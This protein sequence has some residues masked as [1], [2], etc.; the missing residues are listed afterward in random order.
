RCVK[1]RRCWV[2][3][4]KL[5]AYVTFVIGP[6]CAVNRTTAEPPSH[7]ECAI[8]SARNCPFLARPRMVR[9]EDELTKEGQENVAGCPILRNPG[10]AC[11]W[12]TRSYETWEADNR[13]VLLEIG[14][15]L[16]VEWFAEGRKATRAEV[17]ESMRTGMPLLEAE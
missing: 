6:M 8:W 16:E 4:G 5:G 10:V 12:T 7:R 9:R 13:G 17:E 1:E 2:C 15:P 14:D 11:V 3:D